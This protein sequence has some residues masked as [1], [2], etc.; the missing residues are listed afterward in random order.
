M[1]DDVQYDEILIEIAL[2]NLGPYKISTNKLRVDKKTVF[3]IVPDINLDIYSSLYDTGLLLS[4]CSGL[5]IPTNILS[6]YSKRFSGRIHYRE[7]RKEFIG[8]QVSGAKKIQVIPDAEVSIN[9]DINIKEKN[10]KDSKD[11]Y[12]YD[13]S[14]YI[15]ALNYGF[16]K[17]SEKISIF[18][19]LK[20]LDNK[21]SLVKSKYSG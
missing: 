4:N 13:M 6:M 18:K 9:K 19:F 17:F 21:Y 16:E 5:V 15:N 11:Y 10:N 8:T 3:L 12:F 14:I 20:E 2:S 7:T 1:N